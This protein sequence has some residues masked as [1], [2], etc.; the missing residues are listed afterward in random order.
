MDFHG[1]TPAFLNI[2][3]RPKMVPIMYKSATRL[4]SIISW[5]NRILPTIVMTLY[6]NNHIAKIH[7]NFQTE[8]FFIKIILCLCNKLIYSHQPMTCNPQNVN[9]FQRETEK[10][11]QFIQNPK[12]RCNFAA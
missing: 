10:Y 6:Y 7:K 1:A 9:Q 8:H 2:S 3:H 12:K 5:F 4:Y 11:I